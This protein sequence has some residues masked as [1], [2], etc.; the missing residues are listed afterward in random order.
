MP[1][2]FLRPQIT[3]S[4]RWNSV[5]WEAQSFFIRILT[6]VDDYGR[7]DGRA[8]VLWGQC[9]AIWNEKHPDS[10]MTLLRVEQ[11][12]Q[13]LAADGVN[14]VEIY[15]NEGKKVLQINQWAERIREGAKEKWPSKPERAAVVK[16]PAASRSVPLLTT[17]SSPPSSPPPPAAV[18]A[19]PP[20]VAVPLI[21]KERTPAQKESDRKFHFCE[22]VKTLWVARFKSVFADREYQITSP[23][24][25]HLADFSA[26]TT[27]T[28][29]EIVNL[30]ARAWVKRNTKNFS[31]CENSLSISYVCRH[32]NEIE[33]ELGVAPKASGVNRNQPTREKVY[34]Y[35]R[36]K[37]DTQGFAI[38]FYDRWAGRNFMKGGFP[39]DWQVQFSEEFSGIRI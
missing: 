2:R 35:A 12:S 19:S 9:F 27:K 7:H 23:D 22:G 34:E 39:L 17:P 14:L 26:T 15:E 10:V 20:A 28:P 21:K 24:K 16:E 32:Y 33:N 30:A 8:S 29:S 18:V 6:L 36:D 5:S 11:L 38:K 1:Q 37:G 13:E 3:N 4:E 31:H 25:S